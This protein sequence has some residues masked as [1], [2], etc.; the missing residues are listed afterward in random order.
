MKL[1]GGILLTIGTAIGGGMLALPVATAPIGFYHSTLLLF[2]CWL[3]MTSGAFLVLEVNLWLPKDSNLVSMAKLTLG[4]VGQAIA[5]VTCLL[6]LYSLLAAYIAGGSD[7][8]KNILTKMNVVLPAWGVSI[9]FTFVLGAVVYFGIRSVDHVNRVLMAVKLGALI[10]LIGSLAPHVSFSFLSGGELKYLSTSITVALTSFGFATIVPSLRSYFHDD[11]KKL[12]MVIL[13]GSLI[14]LFFYIAWDFTVMGVIPREGSNGLIEMLNSGRSNSEFVNEIGNLLQRD[15]I[16]KFADVFTSICLLT[17]FLGVA[18]CLF[19]FLADGLG[20]VKS[21]W[22]KSLVFAAT[23]FPPL[24]IVL[25][26]PG[27]F[28]SAL[29]YAGIYCIVLLVF[30]PALMAWV[31]RYHKNIVSEFRVPGGKGLLLLLM[32]LSVLIIGQSLWSV[33]S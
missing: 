6:L 23:F 8:L 13:I 20:L 24:L 4:K 9:L 14:P 17:S 16:T 19:D 25:F 30:M 27:V 1:L 29:A 12:R 10:L 21:G 33:F 7:F 26:N 5:W 11:V 22:R 28:I 3:V 18:L 31:G 32:L 15:V 2:G